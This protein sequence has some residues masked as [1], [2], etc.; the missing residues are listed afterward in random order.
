[1]GRVKG[2]HPGSSKDIVQCPVDG[3]IK[4]KV[5]RDNWIKHMKNQVIVGN[6]NKPV[7]QGSL[8]FKTASKEKQNHTLLLI[9]GS[10]SLDNL[11]DPILVEE[12]V[13]D[14]NQD[15]SSMFIKIRPPAASPE[16][17]ETPSVMRHEEPPQLP[18]P[19]VQMVGRISPVSPSGDILP[20]LSTSCPTCQTTEHPCQICRRRVCNFCSDEF[21][22]DELKRVH[23]SCVQS[24][25]PEGDQENNLEPDN[26]PQLHADSEDE[27][28][29]TR[30]TPTSPGP[31]FAETPSVVRHEKT[32]QFQPGIQ[33]MFQRVSTSS[34]AGETS[35][36]VEHKKS[37]QLPTAAPSQKRKRL[38]SEPLS[39]QSDKDTLKEAIR[40]VFEEPGLVEEFATKIDIAQEARKRANEESVQ[41]MKCFERREDGSWCCVICIEFMNHP[42][43]PSACRSNKRGNFGFFQKMNEAERKKK[44]A[45]HRANPL[46]IWCSGV[47]SSVRL[48]EKR[49][50]DRNDQASQIIV[51]TV[52][53]NILDGGGAAGFVRD[54]N[55]LQLTLDGLD[56]KYPTKNDGRQN[57]F[58]L[59]DMLFEE[60][61]SRNQQF[62]SDVKRV[63]ITLDKV[64]LE[65]KSFTPICAYFFHEGVL[66]NILIANYVMS[67]G[68]F[69]C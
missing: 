2:L 1:M 12:H 46:H 68:N 63:F 65:G 52:I 55:L 43:V 51:R 49:D 62:F 58:V 8:Q 53:K 54:C 37:P 44:F 9:S 7:S 6:D 11:P 28:M 25:V 47:A 69:K 66:R 36:V 40:E 15:I 4:V 48:L 3:C 24:G 5:R 45:R 35:C 38:N 29:E 18:D 60:M 59:R 50:Q 31:E 16:T 21:C 14:K 10:F 57:F 61:Q 17:E 13:K 32:A 34:E 19:G 42:E 27:E 33:S 30:S 20:P 67:S 64:T 26:S 56:F 22:G 23:R 41:D 39:I